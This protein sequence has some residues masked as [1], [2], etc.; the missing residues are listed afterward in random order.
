MKFSSRNDL[1]C[2]KDPSARDEIS[3]V[4]PRDSSVQLV[5]LLEE[6]AQV[7][8]RDRHGCFGLAVAFGD[9]VLQDLLQLPGIERLRHAVDP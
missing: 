4:V 3:T 5:E 2:R 7:I 8:V 6:D 1:A 9:H